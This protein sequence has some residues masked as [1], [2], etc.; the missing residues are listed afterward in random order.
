[1]NLKF[2]EIIQDGKVALIIEG[3]EGEVY[4]F[5]R[6]C[7]HS[8]NNVKTDIFIFKV[9]RSLLTSVDTTGQIYLPNEPEQ[10]DP[11]YQISYLSEKD[12]LLFK[13]KWIDGESDFRTAISKTKVLKDETI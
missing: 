10:L 2:T 3:P 11:F 8:F 5:F 7:V 6:W 9:E 4:D 12:L 1:M 13:L